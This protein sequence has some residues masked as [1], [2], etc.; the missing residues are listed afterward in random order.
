LEGSPDNLFVDLAFS[1]DSSSLVGSNRDG[2]LYHWD[3]EHDT[4]VNIL[5][6][7]TFGAYVEFKDENTVVM[8]TS[9][10]PQ[11]ITQDLRDG[12]PM[13]IMT[14]HFSFEESLGD[15]PRNIL[16]GP[17]DLSPD[18]TRITFALQQGDVWVWN[19]NTRDQQMIVEPSLDPER[20]API[21]EVDWAI[22]LNDNA[23]LYANRA[24]DTVYRVDLD[25]GQQTV[26]ASPPELPNYRAAFNGEVIVWLAGDDLNVLSKEGFSSFTNDGSLGRLR[27]VAIS[28]DKGFISISSR[29]SEGQSTILI[30]EL[31]EVMP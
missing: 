10:V 8:M 30:G 15:G 17:F 29:E 31:E 2:Y 4:P 12:A 27:S 13:L 11:V 9:G 6:S 21:G 5:P 26:F 16:R 24:D 18:R 22:F 3:L 19:L 1:P 20:P 28:E 23:V 14:R 25:S 7:L